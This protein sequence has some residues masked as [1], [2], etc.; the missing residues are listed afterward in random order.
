MNK[1]QLQHLLKNKYFY[2]IIIFGVWILFFDQNRLT[3]QFR[4]QQNLSAL[5]AQKDYYLQEI[6]QQNNI[7]KALQNDTV[8]LEKLAREKYLMKRDKE[9]IYVIVKE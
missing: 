6:E 2:T 5:K 9:V 3:N 1:R 7:T 4:L 8:M